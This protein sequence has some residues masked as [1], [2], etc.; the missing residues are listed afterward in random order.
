MTELEKTKSELHSRLHQIAEGA[1]AGIAYH[2]GADWWGSHPFNE[3]KG[4]EAISD[5]WS[6]MRAAMPD[7]E[8]RDSIFIAGYSA[9]DTRPKRDPSGDL[10][11][12]SMGHFQ[13]TFRRDL[14]GIPATSGVVHLRC[15]EAHRVVHGKIDR[16]YVLFDFLD[17]MRQA[18][19]WPIAAS[20][21]SECMWPGPRGS[22]GVR[23]D[24]TRA[25]VGRESLS[26]ILAMHSALQQFDGHSLESMPHGDYWTRQFLWYGPAGIGITRGLEGFR[27]HHQVP[28]LTGFP[29]RKGSGHYMRIG[30]GDFAA[31]GGWPSVVATHT[32]EWLGLPPTGRRV[33]MRVMD[34]YRLDGDLIAENWVPIDIIH[35]LCQLGVDVFARMRH[36]AGHPDPGLLR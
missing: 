8:R 5:V 20:L 13:G 25:S 36:L 24:I 12:A 31:T 29:D 22:G 4:I 3:L 26:T 14:L 17:L 21:G 2:P 32:G 27:A 35:V 34:F 10:V 23:P 18:G 33:G 11:V 1:D 30:D 7:L 19:V 16:S 6:G 9:S 15:C 28:F